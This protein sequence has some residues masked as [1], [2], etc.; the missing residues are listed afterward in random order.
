MAF[1]HG[2]SCE[3]IKSELNIFELPPTQTT[4]EGSQWVHYKPFSSLTD[5]GP[6]E[7]VVPGHGDEYIDTSHTMLNVKVELSSRESRRC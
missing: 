7:F 4:I 5:S 6:I 2:S 3:C 1:L